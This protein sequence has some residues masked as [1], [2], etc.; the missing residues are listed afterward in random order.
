MSGTITAGGLASGLDTNTIID[1]LVELQSKP[2]T[3]LQKRQAGMRTQVSSLGDLAS[4]LSSLDTAVKA[5]GTDGVLGLKATSANTT[6][7][8]T[9]G[10][11]AYPGTSSILVE[12]LAVGA[13]ARSVGFA[14]G[15]AVIGGALSLT[16]QGKAYG[17][18]VTDGES[19]EDLA[20]A[21]RASGA[22]ISAS[23]LTDG[24]TRWLSVAPI[25]TGYPPDGVPDDA[26]TI[27]QHVTGGVGK[28]LDMATTQTADNAKLSIDG[29]EYTRTSNIV[30]DALP[31][32][33][34]TLKSKT[35]ASEDLT[36]GLDADSTRAKLQT[37]VDAYNSVLKLVQSNLA[38]AENTD[39]SATLAGDSALRHLQ[40]QLQSLISA[41]VPGT[42]SV[43]TLADLGVKTSSRDGSLSVDAAALN[44][45][46]ARDPAS[47]NALFSTRKTGLQA[48][49][50][51]LVSSFTKSVT[52][53]LTSR[54]ESLANAAERLDDDL[55]RMQTRVDSYRETLMRQFTA[56]E[57]AVSKIKASGNFLAQQ[58]ASKS[59]S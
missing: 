58:F 18:S 35:G 9:P 20:A 11:G 5:L 1:K 23:I 45:A 30:T 12:N 31:G 44:G 39:R 16:V 46:I 36:V 17:V 52:G 21:L 24:T 59:S 6:F 19:L 41:K 47:V 25:E 56:M 3:Q 33:T 14:P 53:I 42:G 50:S 43:R 26:L 15:D 38:P 48:V 2:L 51:S 13:K 22:P 32:V 55:A 27:T 54:K 28:T 57:D 29:I 37:F 34:L 40:R 49:T 10:S 7:T 8:A 4:R